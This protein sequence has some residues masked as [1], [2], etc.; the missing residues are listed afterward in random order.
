MVDVGHE[1]RDFRFD[2]RVAFQRRP[3]RH[4]NLHE[5]QPAAQVG[6]PRDQRVE[7]GE[8]LRDALRVVQ[9]ID[10]QADDL[11]LEA[12][13]RPQPLLL[14]PQLAIRRDRL[15]AIEVHADRHRH[16][17]GAPAAVIH[18]RGLLLHLDVELLGDSGQEVAPV[19]LH[20]ERQQIVGQQACQDLGAPRA[21]AQ[22]IG[23]RPRDVPEERRAHVGPAR[24][25]RGRD[26]REMV[27]L[28][29]H[30]QPALAE[31]PMDRVGEGAVHLLIGRP[32]LAAELAAARP[33][34]GTAATGPRWRTRRSTPRTSRRRSTGDAACRPAGRAARAR[35]PPHRPPRGRRRPRRA[36]PTRRPA[37]ASPRPA[38]RPR[39]RW[40]AAPPRCR[41]PAARGD[42]ARGSR[43]RA[44]AAARAD[45]ARR[46]A[47]GPVETPRA[48]PAR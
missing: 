20:L 21:D 2:R 38:P 39:R 14:G 5:R 17:G 15:D 22:P 47:R 10:A 33:P 30:L 3:R 37:R 19:A 44:A 12:Q 29:E 8:P 28:D 43:P 1:S 13:Q 41:P 46:P 35:D 9:P 18:P 48:P 40:R 7:R 32:V 36:P 27:V 26:Q 42:R 6:P 25:Q 11:G 34:G 31:L 45:P 16:H 4:A 23:I 24:A